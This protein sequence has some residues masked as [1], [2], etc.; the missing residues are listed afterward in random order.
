VENYEVFEAPCMF[1][2]LKPSEDFLGKN[3]N[4]G[5]ILRCSQPTVFDVYSDICWGFLF[6]EK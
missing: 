4:I 5:Q 1:P 2:M 3:G 6:M